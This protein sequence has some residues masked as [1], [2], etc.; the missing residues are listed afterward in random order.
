MISTSIGPSIGSTTVGRGG[1]PVVVPNLGVLMASGA[2]LSKTLSM[3]AGGGD[4]KVF[5]LMAWFKRTA[6]M[7]DE[8]AI[9][10][11]QGG[12]TPYAQAYLRP[13]INYSLDTGQDSDEGSADVMPLNTWVH[14]CLSSP[15]GYAGEA[16]L[17]VN[18]I[19]IAAAD[20]TVMAAAAANAIL[21]RSADS[22]FVGAVTSVKYGMTTGHLSQAEIIA[23]SQTRASINQALTAVTLNGHTNLGGF[24][25]VGSI[26][27]T[28]GP[29]G[30]VT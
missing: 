25:S 11:E 6:A 10:L 16:L 28:P 8:Y 22:K 17:K 12:V 2:Q 14:L 1:A 24:T 13:G 20:S 23:E 7:P 3:P 30:L 19:Q 18:G 9:V 4:G 21:G 5:H 26:S 29:T 27:S 15:Y